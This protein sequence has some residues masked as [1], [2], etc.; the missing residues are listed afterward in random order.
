MEPTDKITLRA[1]V[2]MTIEAGDAEGGVVSSLTV[3]LFVSYTG[4]TTLENV[5]LIASCHAPIFLTADTVVLPS[6]AGGN[7][8]PTIVP[9]TFRA[10]AHELPISLAA[11]VMAS[12]SGP[13]GEPRCARCDVTLPLPMVAE[14][15]APVKQSAF[16]IT[17]ETNRMPPPIGELFEDVLAK[18]P[19]ILQAVTSGAVNAVSLRYYCGLDATILMS[20]NS[21]RFRIQ[22]STFE[23]LWLLADECVRPHCTFPR[24]LVFYSDT[25]AR[26][27]RHATLAGSCGALCRTTRSRSSRSLA[28][29]RLS[30]CM[31]SRCRYRST[32]S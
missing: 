24:R 27:S 25:P 4:G 15:V 31:R 18:Q 17:L 7:R 13:N 5:T 6:L 12:Y 11:T 3:R 2:P 16:K 21:G 26:W 23:G 29:I 22:S 1:Q 19:Q 9:F 14:P 8:T 20:K 30:S 32:S 28:R 10:R